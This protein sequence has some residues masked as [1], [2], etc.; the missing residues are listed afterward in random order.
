VSVHTDRVI[1]EERPPVAYLG[2]GGRQW[3]AVLVP[4]MAMLV[5]V[6]LGYAVVNWACAKGSRT[7][8][9]VTA[10]LTLLAAMAAGLAARG[11][12]RRGGG[13]RTD[14]E[15]DAAARARFL[16]V[17]GMA[18]SALFSVTIVAQWIANVYLAPCDGT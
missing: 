7:L 14:A 9:H 15:P 11:E 6:G 5:H 4:A 12:W 16:G 3:L 2:R 18:S 17:L 10:A 8:V 1:R 13:R